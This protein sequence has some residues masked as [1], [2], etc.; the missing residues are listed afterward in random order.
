MAYGVIPPQSEDRP[1]GQPRDDVE[2]VARHYGLTIKEA[3]DLLR[4]YTVDELLPE[5]GTGLGIA[6]WE[7]GKQ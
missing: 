5:R 3:C 2:R 6:I 7:R 1:R 4:R